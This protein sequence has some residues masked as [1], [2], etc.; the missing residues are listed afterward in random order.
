M[1]DAQNFHLK[2]LWIKSKVFTF[3]APC[4]EAVRRAAARRD[5]TKGNNDTL[6][7]IQILKYEKSKDFNAQ[8]TDKK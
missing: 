7:K 2:N 5:C 6:R 1:R 4:H 8:D 3:A